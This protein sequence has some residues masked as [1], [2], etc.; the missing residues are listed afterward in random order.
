MDVPPANRPCPFCEAEISATAKKCRHCGEWLTGELG[1]GSGPAGRSAPE[2]SSGESF[3]PALGAGSL[4]TGR[5]RLERR[6]GKGGMAEVWA[7]TD[8]KLSRRVAIKTIPSIV[9]EDKRLRRALEDEA[10]LVMDLHHE[11]IRAVH[12]LEEDSA[13]GSYLVMELVEGL[14][15]NDVLGERGGGRLSAEEAA[16]IGRQVCEGVD[17]AH[18][19]GVIHRDLK[20]KNLFLEGVT[21]ADVAK[22]LDLKRIQVKVMDFGLGVRVRD[23]VVSRSGI[24]AE[25]S[26]TLAYMSPEQVNGEKPSPSMDIYSVGATLY[27]LLTGDPPFSGGDVPGQILRKAASRVSHAP[28]WLADAV[29]ACL[30]KEAS[31]RPSSIKAARKRL[32]PPAVVSPVSP[33]APLHESSPAPPPPLAREF[34]REVTAPRT[35]TP[36]PGRSNRITPAQATATLRLCVPSGC[37]PLDSS[38]RLYPRNPHPR[39]VGA[40]KAHNVSLAIEHE[41][42]GMAM[43]LIP[44]GTFQMG[45]APQDVA[46]A[47]D[48]EPRHQVTIEKAFYIGA[49]PVTVGAY[50]RFSKHLM[51][52]APRPPSFNL[53]WKQVDH[54]VVNVSWED[55]KAFCESTRLRLP[56]EAEWEYAARG[57]LDGKKYPWGDEERSDLA[58]GARFGE[59]AGTCPVATFDP[60]GFGL[61]DAAGNVWEWVEDHWHDNYSGAPTD[62]RAWTAAGNSRVLRGGSWYLVPRDLRVSSR[63]YNV[64]A[65]RYDGFGFRCSLDAFP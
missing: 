17:H 49:T 13:A 1:P 12:G 55:A 9:M 4:L 27:E 47:N 26:G 18:G 42:T 37:K 19:K 33:E 25:T 23:S 21:A 31:R 65:T 45:A 22:P 28:S 54:P 38:H 34:V 35:P 44:S 46:A 43:V 7:A 50:L 58:N 10:K 29:A 41:A 56:S 57:G 64:A 59:R 32:D 14:S 5:Y 16:E 52:D 62:G 63:N 20:P 8:E 2:A 3:L 60:N 30:E 61:F 48:A 39:Q 40:A 53:G 51:N 6:L 36:Q 15:L 11:R 24:S